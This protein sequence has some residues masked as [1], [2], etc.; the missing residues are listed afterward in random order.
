M[1]AFTTSGNAPLSVTFYVSCAAGT[2]YNVVFGD[3]TDLGSSGIS[4]AKCTSGSLDAVTHTYQN[5][6]SYSPELVIFVQQSTGTIVPITVQT[7]SISVSSV[8]SNYSYNP[9]SLSPNGSLSFALSFDLPT[10][11][12]GYS[13]S[14]GDGYT[15]SQADGGTSCAQ[16]TS[17]KSVSHTYTSTGSYTITLKRGPALARA[18]DISVTVSD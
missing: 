2:A 5:A 10:S 17:S 12:T 13:I 4:N 6:G 9:P 14:W 11:C 7:L 16:T 1:S 3:G 8:T 18:D 15:A